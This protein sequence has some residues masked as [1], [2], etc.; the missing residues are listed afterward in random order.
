M[1][2]PL[3]S[4]AVEAAAS[5]EKPATVH[6]DPFVGG[7][8]AELTFK[9]EVNYETVEQ[10]LDGR[11]EGDGHRLRSHALSNYPIQ[12]HVEGDRT[13]YPQVDL[14]DHAAAGQDQ[15][16]LSDLKKQVAA[17]PIFP[18]SNTIGGGRGRQHAA[19]GRLRPGG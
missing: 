4:E 5:D 12:M 13:P 1:R 17:T 16:L 14:E 3:P 11:H 9:T 6:S 2:K 15:A 19:P 8:Q 7:S 10:M 18:A